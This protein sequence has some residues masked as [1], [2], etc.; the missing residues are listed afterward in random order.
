MRMKVVVMNDDYVTAAGDDAVVPVDQL[1]A[2]RGE[3]PELG[4]HSVVLTA[5]KCTPV[6]NSAASLAMGVIGRS[7]LPS[8]HQGDVT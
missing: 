1:Q 6:T 5:Y 3:R 7:R 8:K 2:T 4:E